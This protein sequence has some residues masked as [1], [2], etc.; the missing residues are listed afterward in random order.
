MYASLQTKRRILQAA[1]QR[2]V[3]KPDNTRKSTRNQMENQSSKSR[4][5]TILFFSL[6]FREILNG[7]VELS[8]RN[9]KIR[10]IIVLG[11]HAGNPQQNTY[12]DNP[13]SAK[14]APEPIPLLQITHTHTQSYTH[15]K[16]LHAKK[17][18]HKDAQIKEITKLPFGR[19]IFFVQKEPKWLLDMD[20]NHTVQTA[21]HRILFILWSRQRAVTRA[22]R[23]HSHAVFANQSPKTAAYLAKGKLE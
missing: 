17:C 1:Q 22:Q 11:M 4:Q 10:R 5:R 14:A 3:G 2:T 13:P 8:A 6:K 16:S 12:P 9:L 20:L 23:L 15:N 18:A 19:R 7:A 21:D